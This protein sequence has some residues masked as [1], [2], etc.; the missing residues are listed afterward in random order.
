[1]ISTISAVDAEGCPIGLENESRLKNRKVRWYET[2]T[3]S[4]VIP[5]RKLSPEAE[6]SSLEEKLKAVTESLTAA[7]QKAG[8]NGA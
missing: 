6:I 4:T 2:G 3:Y 8:G 1:M 5:W 7:G